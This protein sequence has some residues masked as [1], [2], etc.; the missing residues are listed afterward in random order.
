MG[1]DMK[2]R[3]MIG[4]AMLALTGLSACATAPDKIGAASVSTLQYQDYSC[5]Q[6]GMELDRVERKTN[7]IYYRLDKKASDDNAQMAVGMLLF[8]PTLFFLEG[9]DGPEATEYARL[10]GEVEALE[11]VAA[12]KKCSI[13]FPKPPITKKPAPTERNFN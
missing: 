3:R 10:K 7:E 13:A 5:K 8:W 12:R 6:I 2:Q 11:T 4:L 9:S 1:R